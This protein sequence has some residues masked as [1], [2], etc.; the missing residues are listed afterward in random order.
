MDNNSVTRAFKP[1]NFAVLVNLHTKF[2]T[3]LL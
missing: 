1:L 3:N 2:E